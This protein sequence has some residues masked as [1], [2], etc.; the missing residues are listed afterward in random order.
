MIGKQ[1]MAVFKSIG[2][3]QH[4]SPALCPKPGHR[5]S[6]ILLRYNIGQCRLKSCKLIAKPRCQ[7]RFRQH[8]LPL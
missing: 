2:E 6:T 8:L 5:I 4:L 3:I 7:G 1:A